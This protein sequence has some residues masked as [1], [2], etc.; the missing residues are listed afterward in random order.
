MSFLEYYLQMLLFTAAVPLG[1]SLLIGIC[2]KMFCSLVGTG[3]GRPILLALHAFLTP[4]REFAHLVAAVMT[5]H[6]V[7]D[8][9]L[10]NLHDP[11]GELGF[12]EHSYNRRNPIAVFGN[13]LFAV[14]PAALGLFLSMLTVFVCFRGAFAGLSAST[15]AL[16]EADAGFLAYAKLA[17][18]FLPAMFRDATTGVFGKIIGA[19]VLLLLSLG[20]YVSLEDL[21]NALGGI[22]YYAL[23]VLLFAG[24]TALFDARARRL[25]L[26]N[27]RTFATGVTA[28]FIVVLV[29][30][31]AALAVGFL[32]FLIRTLLG[33]GERGLVLYED[34]RYGHRY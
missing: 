3:R 6:H 23:I 24:V 32:I 31:V 12:V 22:I 10:L 30:A 15:A 7:G 1:F 9:C 34:D 16:V 33:D 21:A 2:N 19:L 25:I 11:E 28:L 20:V 29:F 18:G 27:F 5:F 14:L 26:L 8:F 4:V 13:Y 17:V